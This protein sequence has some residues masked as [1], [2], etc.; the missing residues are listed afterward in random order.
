MLQRK[1]GCNCKSDPFLHRNLGTF[2]AEIVHVRST[3]LATEDDKSESN[4]ERKQCT[5]S[6]ATIRYLEKL[7]KKGTH[8]TSV[9]KVMTSLIEEGIRQAIKDRFIKH[10]DDDSEA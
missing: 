6:L 8:G 2:G 7:A 1:Q 3:S 5:L 9:P 4:T 10:E